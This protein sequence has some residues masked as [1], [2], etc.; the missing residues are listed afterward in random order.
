MRSFWQAIVRT[1]FWSYDRGSWPYDVLVIA[2]VVFVL[3][4]PGRWFHD[5]PQSGA[6]ANASVELISNDSSGGTR[7]YRLAAAA[8]SPEKRAT[9]PTPELE[10]QTHDIL[11]RTVDDLKDRTFQVLR[12]DPVLAANGSVLYYDVTVRP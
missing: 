6:G 11:G 2:I 8:L 7:I 10:R 1:V 9:K 4:T 12:I 5:R 3:A